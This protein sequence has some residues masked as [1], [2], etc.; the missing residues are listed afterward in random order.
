MKN[1]IIFLLLLSIGGTWLLSCTK[2]TGGSKQK[3]PCPWPDI[4]T[5]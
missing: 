2:D 4:T 3:D 5:E 1:G